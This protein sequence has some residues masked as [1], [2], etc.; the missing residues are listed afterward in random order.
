MKSKENMTPTMK[1]KEVMTP[2]MN[3]KANLSPPMKSKENLSPPTKSK[4]IKTSPSGF[5]FDHGNEIITTNNASKSLIF[6][7]GSK[8]T[9][10]IKNEPEIPFPKVNVEQERFGKKESNEGIGFQ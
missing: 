10:N 1:T 5:I 7:P 2:T 6:V 4:G 3:L 8:Q 9:E